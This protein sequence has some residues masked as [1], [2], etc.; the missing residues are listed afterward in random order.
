[1]D[2]LHA[3]WIDCSLSSMQLRGWSTECG[4]MITW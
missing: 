4:S 3:N 1:M 2:Y